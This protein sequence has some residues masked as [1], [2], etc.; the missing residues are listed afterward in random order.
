MPAYRESTK[1]KDYSVAL[2][3]IS[4]VP[5]TWIKENMI[6]LKSQFSVTSTPSLFPI[7]LNF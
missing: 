6:F 5:W 3:R 2:L 7:P 1:Y 4:Q